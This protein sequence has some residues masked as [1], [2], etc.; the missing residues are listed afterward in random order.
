MCGWSRALLYWIMVA[1]N[2]KPPSK[3]GGFGLDGA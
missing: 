2:K 1:Q 3:L